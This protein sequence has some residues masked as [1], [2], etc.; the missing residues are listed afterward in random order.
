MSTWEAELNSAMPKSDRSAGIEACHGALKHKQWMAADV[1]ALAFMIEH[2]Q[3][4]RRMPSRALKRVLI[5]QAP[6]LAP[7]QVAS[8][9]V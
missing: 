3:P 1:G 5:I 6:H 2:Q 9:S 8:K 4:Y 7:S